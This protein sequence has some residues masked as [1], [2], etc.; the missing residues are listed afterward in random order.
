MSVNVDSNC[1]YENLVP[2]NFA[3]VYDYYLY[4]AIRKFLLS[5]RCFSVYNLDNIFF[6]SQCCRYYQDIKLMPAI[7]DQDMNSML[8][9]ET[10]VCDLLYFVIKCE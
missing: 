5:K 3:L 9:E 8:V 4:I 1:N 7:S 6:L 10:R 2:F